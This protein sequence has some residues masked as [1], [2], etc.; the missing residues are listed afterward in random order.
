MIIDHLDKFKQI[1]LW[2]IN[3][4]GIIHV[5]DLLLISLTG[6]NTFLINNNK[7]HISYFAYQG[8]FLNTYK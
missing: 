4:V 5:N 1:M 6:I 3:A 8:S 7:K 2:H